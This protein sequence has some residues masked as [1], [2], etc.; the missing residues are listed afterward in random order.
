M[1]LCPNILVVDDDPSVRFYLE[2]ALT[3]VGYRVAAVGSGEAALELI[4]SQEFDL[5]LLDLQLGGIGG[6]E[7]LAKLRQRSPETA[8]IVLT[9]HASLETAVEALRQ[10][11]RDYLFKPC[12][13]A[14]LRESVRAAL[15]KRQREVQQRDLL[16]QLEQTLTNSLAVIQATVQEELV[17]TAIP[18]SRSAGEQTRFIEWQGLIL[19][20]ER[21]MFTLDDQLLELSPTEF[22]ML[23]YLIGEAPRVVSAQELVREVQGY[24]SERWEARDVVRYHVYRIRRK[25]KEATGCTGLIRTVRG[26]GYAMGDT[27]Q[28]SR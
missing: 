2:Q 9:A 3:R 17:P 6:M 26:V 21:H 4:A 25:V 19:D 18:A 7:V 14:R 11:A 5:A 24:E 28:P 23:V 8:V 20:T 10:G 13:T 1:D 27:F 12:K 16:A 22:S 15:V